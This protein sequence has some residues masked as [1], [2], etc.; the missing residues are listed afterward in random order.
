MKKIITL[1]I[2]TIIS[3]AL[4]A[5]TEHLKFKGVPIDGTLEKFSDALI[6]IGFELNEDSEKDEMFL[7]G[8]FAGYKDCRVYVSTLDNI[9]LVN[10]V[11]VSFPERDSWSTLLQDYTSLKE[12]LTEKYG[13]PSEDVEDIPNENATSN[14]DI[15]FE[16]KTDNYDYHSIFSTDEGVIA[17]SIEHYTLLFVERY[18]VAIQY[19]DKINSDIIRE[20]AINDL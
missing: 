11:S 19:Y 5:Q 12:M 10:H 6:A 1:T 16:I 3:S 2:C 9:D 7:I 15:L 4:L 13:A 14:S 8:D 18:F 17:L 20:H